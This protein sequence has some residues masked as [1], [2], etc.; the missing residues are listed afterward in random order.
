MPKKTAVSG[1]TY[2]KDSKI[3]IIRVAQST[4]EQKLLKY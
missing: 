1:T 2:L 4:G 3:I